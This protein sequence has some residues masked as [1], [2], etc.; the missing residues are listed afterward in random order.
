MKSF[1]VDSYSIELICIGIVSCA[2][3]FLGFRWYLEHR[4][5]SFKKQIDFLNRTWTENLKSDSSQDEIQYLMKLVLERI[6]QLDQHLNE[7]FDRIEQKLEQIDR[8]LSTIQLI[9]A[10]EDFFEENS[11]TTSED[12]EKDTKKYRF[13]G[14]DGLFPFGLS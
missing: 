10:E 4:L 11:N 13:R 14:E 7:R 6:D 5:E 2:V 12:F 9:Q 3:L 1:L 8:K